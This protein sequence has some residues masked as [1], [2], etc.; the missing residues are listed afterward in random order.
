MNGNAFRIAAAAVIGLL[1]IAGGLAFLGRSNQGIGGQPPLAT[2]TPT[3]TA[4]ASPAVITPPPVRVNSA[5]TTGWVPFV[6]DRYG[7]EISHPPTAVLYPASTDWSLD[8]GG[9][10]RWMASDTFVMGP[11]GSQVAATGFAADVPAGMTQDEWIAAADWGDSDDPCRASETWE[12]VMVD[13]HEA[14]FNQQPGAAEGNGCEATI[15]Y[16][17]IGDRVYVFAEWLGEFPELLRGFLSTVRFTDVGPSSPP[18][19]PAP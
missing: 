16:V 4:P 5:D 19:T 13:G 1:V 3:P 9:D 14:R 10:D 18:A 2:P 7:Y 11:D 17:F 6:S 15:A 12:T 8:L